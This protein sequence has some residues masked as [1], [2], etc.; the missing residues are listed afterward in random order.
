MKT[1]TQKAAQSS[2]AGETRRLIEAAARQPG[3]AELFKVYE[4]WQKFDQ[5]FE[6][7]SQFMAPKQFVSTSSSSVPAMC[8]PA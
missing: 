4:V 6:T 8:E 5:V 7:Q 2:D 1:N 3:V